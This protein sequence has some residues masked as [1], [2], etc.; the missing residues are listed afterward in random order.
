M[1]WAISWRCENLGNLRNHLP[2]PA[3]RRIKLSA[4]RHKWSWEQK[5]VNGRHQVVFFSL[6]QLLL[7]VWFC[8]ILLAPWD[9]IFASLWLVLFL[10]CL[11]N[12][13]DQLSLVVVSLVPKIL[14][15]QRLCRSDL[16]IM[17]VGLLLVKS[18]MGKP[19]PTPSKDLLL[20]WAC[21]VVKPYNQCS[22]LVMAL[23]L[24]L[25]SFA[26]SQE[27]WTH[28]PLMLFLDYAGPVFQKLR[29]A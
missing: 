15:T 8:L 29:C 9:K 7:R 28:D 10:Q 6:L 16:N 17:T 5:G 18:P 26:I 25:S 12:F 1:W 27:Q 11:I 13:S 3:W 14:F 2:S 22:H 20:T 4:L 23:Q 21:Q 19:V 24:Y